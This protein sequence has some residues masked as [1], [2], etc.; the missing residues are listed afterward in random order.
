MKYLLALV[1][2]PSATPILAHPG[3]HAVP[4]SAD[5]TWLPYLAAITVAAALTHLAWVK[6]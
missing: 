5:M 4:H 1:L 6:S 3:V 2:I